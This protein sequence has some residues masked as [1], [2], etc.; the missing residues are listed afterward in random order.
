MI[1]TFAPSER[2]NPPIVGPGFGPG[3]LNANPATSRLTAGR[4]CLHW[5]RLAARRRSAQHLRSL[6]MPLSRVTPCASAI[7][8]AT[9]H[10]AHTGRNGRGRHLRNGRRGGALDGAAESK[11]TS[12]CRTVPARAT[13]RMCRRRRPCRPPNGHPWRGDREPPHPRRAVRSRICHGRVARRR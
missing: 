13:R 7:S 6:S 12:P 9:T 2:A 3:D 1:G 4:L 8:T 11:R 5:Q 10:R